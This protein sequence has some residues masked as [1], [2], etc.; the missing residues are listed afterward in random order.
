MKNAFVGLISSLDMVMENVS[1]LV[2]E[3]SKTESFEGGKKKRTMG[4]LQ[5][6]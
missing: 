1:E 6:V 4:P 5:N 3:T 2:N